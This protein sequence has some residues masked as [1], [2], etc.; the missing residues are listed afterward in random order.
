MI[1]AKQAHY[2]PADYQGDNTMPRFQPLALLALSFAVATGAHAADAWPAKPI[3]WI[4]PYPAGGGSDFLARTIG[5]GLSARVNQ[6]SEEHTSELQ[7]H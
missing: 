6:R 1:Y 7:S 5:Q 3:R 4:V 2:Y